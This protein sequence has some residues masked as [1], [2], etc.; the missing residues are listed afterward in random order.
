MHGEIYFYLSVQGLKNMKNHDNII[1][2]STSKKEKFEKLF[3]ESR[4]KLFSV[5]YNVVRNRETAEDVLQTSYVKAWRNFNA[6]DP[7][8]KFTNWMTSI[9][10][11]ASI[12]A[13]RNKKIQLDSFSLEYFDHQNNTNDTYDV[14]DNSVDLT[15]DIIRKE[16][17]DELFVMISNL[18]ADLREI[19]G[20]IIEEKS[21]K[22]ISEEM[23]LPLTTIRTKVHRAKK[24][25][26]NNADPQFLAN[27]A[28]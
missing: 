3:A 25:L 23:N 12:D 1:M 8:K 24:M 21:Y 9:V 26:R 10:R 17:I 2:D 19:M 15:R 4:V 5:A 28:V 16:S 6:Y 20:H 27:F 13:I 18:P 14:V 7:E 11:N 22:E